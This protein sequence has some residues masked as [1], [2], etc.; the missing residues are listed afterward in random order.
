MRG[1]VKS[2]HEDNCVELTQHE[3][4]EAFELCKVRALH[5]EY[6]PEAPPESFFQLTIEPLKS[7]IDPNDES[8][9]EEVT[10]LPDGN[11]LA[12]SFPPDHEDEELYTFSDNVHLVMS[13]GIREA[14]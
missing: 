10:L 14:V 7:V 3:D 13:V 11:V 9:F 4:A 6:I 8:D 1:I 2:S 5:F 12:I